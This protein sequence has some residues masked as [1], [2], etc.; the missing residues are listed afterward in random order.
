VDCKHAR[1]RCTIPLTLDFCDYRDAGV[2]QIIHDGNA[3][4]RIWVKGQVKGAGEPKGGPSGD[5]VSVFS[6]L[7][8]S[9]VKIGPRLINW[10]V[11]YLVV[12]VYVGMGVVGSIVALRGPYSYLGLIIAVLGFVFAAVVLHSFRSRGPVDLHRL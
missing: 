7:L 3:Y 8:P 12:F 10:Y 2:V 6:R 1:A 9:V 5:P 4:T 11:R